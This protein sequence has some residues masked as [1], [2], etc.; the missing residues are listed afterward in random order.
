[1]FDAL[2]YEEQLKIVQETLKEG[3]ESDISDQSFDE[4]F[5]YKDT[6]I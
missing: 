2:S 1:L 4:I 3:L 5:G 6:G